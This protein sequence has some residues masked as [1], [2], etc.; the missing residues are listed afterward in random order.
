MISINDFSQVE[1]RLG[2]ILEVERVPDTDKLLKLSV[3]FNEAVPRQ[4]ISG[5][6]PYLLDAVIYIVNKYIG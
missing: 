6:A 3:N 5:I 1:M 4:V 2:T